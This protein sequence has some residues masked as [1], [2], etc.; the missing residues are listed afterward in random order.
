MKASPMKG[1]WIELL[2]DDLEKVGLTLEDESNISSLTK[3]AFK[4]QIKKEIRKL[5][6]H[7]LETIKSEHEKV[8]NIGHHNLDK[9][10]ECLTSGLFTK[11]QRSI[12][13]NLRSMSETN[14]RDNFHKMYQDKRCQICKLELDQQEHALT[15]LP[16]QHHMNHEDISMLK[17][18]SYQNIF[19]N[20][21][22]QLQITKLYLTIIRIKRR[23]LK[24]MDLPRAAPPGTNSGPNG[25][26]V[27]GI[28][29]PVMEI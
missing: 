18:V 5:S 9:P 16:I 28:I 17:E 7:E 26:V 4:N 8:K 3:Y 2:K 10:Q 15:C 11:A 23:L 29:T 25:M 22:A 27:P 6:Q 13:L 19:G 12:L 1:D 20:I 24:S 14:F 21:H